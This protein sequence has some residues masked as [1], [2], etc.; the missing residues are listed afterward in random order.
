[1]AKI[2]TKPSG[3]SIFSDIANAGAGLAVGLQREKEKNQQRRVEQAMRQ[4]EQQMQTEELGLKQEGVNLQRDSLLFQKEQTGIENADREQQRILQ[5]RQFEFQRGEAGRRAGEFQSEMEFRNRELRQRAE[6]AALD[7]ELQRKLKRFDL[8]DRANRDAMSYYNTE[9]DNL[10]TALQDME[11]DK[12]LVGEKYNRVKAKADLTQQLSNPKLAPEA[13]AQLQTK[14]E[15]LERWSELERRKHEVL[16]KIRKLNTEGMRLADESGGVVPAPPASEKRWS[17]YAPA[18]KQGFMQN[19][20]EKVKADLQ[21]TGKEPSYDALEDLG[22]TSEEIEF[23]RDQALAAVAP[24]R[25]PAVTQQPIPI[26]ERAGLQNPSPRVLAPSKTPDQ[27]SPTMHMAPSTQQAP[28]V[29]ARGSMPQMQPMYNFSKPMSLPQ[30]L[31]SSPMISDSTKHRIIKRP[32][33]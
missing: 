27:T 8:A 26:S 9:H 10:R 18:E 7:R 23:I 1:M 24:P 6:Q 20:V 15:K 28:D 12:D 5:N 3:G 30:G 32:F 33:P 25:L 11:K 17:D 14:L 16:D 31:I 22:L 4:F 29:T 13:R 2:P 21:S 19:A